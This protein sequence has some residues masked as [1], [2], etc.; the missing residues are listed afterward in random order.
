MI[1]LVAP[2]YQSNHARR[3]RKIFRHLY[4]CAAPAMTPRPITAEA[5]R[6]C[7]EQSTRGGNSYG[8]DYHMLF[9]LRDGLIYEVREYMNPLMA[10]PLMGELAAMGGSA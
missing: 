5:D 2:S 4:R 1:S 8:D 10:A 9:Q 7:V 6:V 3:S